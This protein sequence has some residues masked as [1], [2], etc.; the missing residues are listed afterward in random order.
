MQKPRYDIFLRDI[1]WLSVTAFG[2][3][4]GHVARFIDLLVDKRKY[5]T[6]EEFLELNALCQIL[7]GPTSSQT[8]VAIGFQIGGPRLAYLT[9]LIWCTPA[10]VL[11]TTFELMVHFLQ[12][13]NISLD[14]MRYLQPVVVG[15]VCYAAFRLTILIVDTKTE[16]FITLLSAIFAFF[17][18]TPWIFPIAVIFGGIIS[19][20]LKYKNQEEEKKKN[21]KIRWINFTLFWGIMLVS[22][23][24][25]ETTD[26]PYIRLF[27]N[28]YRNGSF[29]FG[30]GQVLMPVLL[31]E[32][33][34]YKG[35]LTN[36]EFLSGYGLA[37]V[38]PGPVF[39]F[40][41]FVGVLSIH[42]HGIEGQLLA[43]FLASAGIFLPGTFLIFFVIRFWE[44]LK[45]YRII[46]ASL[47]GITAA[48]TGLVI[49]ASMVLLEPQGVSY[50]N[51]SIVVLTFLLLQ[52]TK[53]PQ[54]FFIIAALIVGLII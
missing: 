1:A 20:S 23:I 6:E 36:E 19:A 48:S 24:L 16:I 38:V 33:V 44:E 28:F 15:F 8:I 12:T 53:I 34:D 4:Q 40:A 46:K 49:A 21:I 42:E 51:L 9:L 7:P 2:G 35:F 10:V 14:F 29:V 18:R 45:K 5:L 13:S 32:F 26:S 54:P 41:S 30:G 47:E 17:F 31:T 52:F 27:V 39:A 3:P 25:A 22:W 50:I 37:Q 11:M 43:A